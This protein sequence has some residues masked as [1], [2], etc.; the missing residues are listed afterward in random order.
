M[1]TTYVFLRW[2]D[3]TD[4][5]AKRNWSIQTSYSE[6][7]DSVKKRMVPIIGDQYRVSDGEPVPVGML[8]VYFA[9]GK[10]P[11]GDGV[12]NMPEVYEFE[13]R[14]HLPEIVERHG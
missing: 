2:D 10:E 7:P 9:S 5:H 3:P 11:G 6:H 14:R 4:C 8:L 12:L 1:M 13:I